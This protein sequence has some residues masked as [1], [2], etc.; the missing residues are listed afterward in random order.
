MFDY[1]WF[2]GNAYQQQKR[3]ALLRVA[4]RK[5]PNQERPS[6]L[7]NKEFRAYTDE[8]ECRTL[9]YLRDGYSYEMKALT[10]EIDL[11][12]HLTF[13]CEPVDELYKV[14]SFVI[15]VPFEE[16]ARV[17]IFVVHPSEKPEDR[18]FITGFRHPPS[19]ETKRE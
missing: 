5:F 17:E 4:L 2:Y 15:S 8:L 1:D 10:D 9:I 12:A 14:G 19:E 13:E 3:E 18:P 16:I 11:K 7:D 6:A